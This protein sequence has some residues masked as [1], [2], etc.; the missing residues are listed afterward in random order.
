MVVKIIINIYVPINNPL[1]IV[2]IAISYEEHELCS[3]TE[4]IKID[5]P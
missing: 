4:F 2:K 5:M 3:D 1:S